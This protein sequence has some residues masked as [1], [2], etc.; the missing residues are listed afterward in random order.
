MFC[1]NCGASGHVYK[2]CP[3]DILS[4]GIILIRDRSMKRPTGPIPV[5]HQEFLLVRRKHS[6]GFVEFMRGKYDL[7]NM[8]YIRQLW[9]E[10]TEL[11]RLSLIAR[12]FDDLWNEMWNFDVSEYRMRE[13]AG[14]LRKMQALNLQEL[15]LT[16][17][18]V[19]QYA[20]WGF[21]KGRK[22]YRESDLN[23][24]KRECFEEANVRPNSYEIIWSHPVEERFQ[25]SNGLWYKHRYFLA[26]PVHDIIP[27][28]ET[29]SQQDE[30]GD[31]RWMTLIDACKHL[32]TYQFYRTQ[33]LMNISQN[34]SQLMF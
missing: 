30:V 22:N 8:N 23:C 5:E 2:S 28:I 7:A 24:A 27:N 16:T 13:K 1:N 31:I 25:G 29:K 32:R 4:C 14:S 21:P 19:W 11:E 6:I 20:E 15:H 26:T 17:P 34:I 3:E 10:M 18:L 9:S 33:L 12:P